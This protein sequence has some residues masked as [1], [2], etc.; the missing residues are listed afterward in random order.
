MPWCV[1]QRLL[2]GHLP[3][4]KF[5]VGEDAADLALLKVHEDAHDLPA[6]LRRKLAVLFAHVLAQGRLDAGGVDELNLALAARL[7]AVTQHPDIGADACVVKHLL[8]QGDDRL[9][10]VVFDHVA[11]GVALAAACV[12][13][14]Q[15]GTVVYLHNAAAQRG[16][17]LHLADVVEQEEQLAV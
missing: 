2:H 5:A 11:A 4:A 17:L 7:L 14:E 1:E 3:I 8:R 6:L 13:G 10:Q 12:A 16:I 15:A 9:H